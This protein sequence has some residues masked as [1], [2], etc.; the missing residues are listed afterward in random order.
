M[1]RGMWMQHETPPSD[2]EILLNA[3]LSVAHEECFHGRWHELEPVMANVWN[4]LRSPECPPWSEVSDR[5]RIVCEGEGL[6][7]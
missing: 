5:V 2:D 7:H 6:L 4:R 3:V 1:H